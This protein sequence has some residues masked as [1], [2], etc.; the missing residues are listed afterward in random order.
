MEGG[1]EME[2]GMDGGERRI[3]GDGERER[4]R[5]GRDDAEL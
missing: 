5:E 2:K 3:E 1:R 4:G